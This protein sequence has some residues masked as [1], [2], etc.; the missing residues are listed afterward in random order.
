MA[1]GHPAKR[2]DHGTP[3]PHNQPEAGAVAKRSPGATDPVL[4]RTRILIVDDHPMMRQ[5]LAQVIRQHADLEVCGETDG[6]VEGLQMIKAMS[7]D[8]VI[9]DIALK[10]GHGMDLIRDVRAAGIQVRLLV[11]SMHEEPTYAERALRAGAHGYLPKSE[12]VEQVIEAIRSV[13]RGEVYLVPRMMKRLLTNMVGGGLA[14]AAS[15]EETLSDRELQVFEL[16]GQGMG[17]R[18]IAERLFLS[19]KTIDTYRD[20]LKRK[21]GAAN[22]NE[23]M[24]QA[25]LWVHGRKT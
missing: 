16:L 5:G 25:I 14:P 22:G 24:L 9:V 10:D 8:L 11:M 23:L 15:P 19:I 21:L 13:L 18:E 3:I 12:G 1:M 20:H 17:S 2:V 6:V 4:V 7:P